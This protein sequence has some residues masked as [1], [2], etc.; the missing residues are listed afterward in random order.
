MQALY[1][2]I[3]EKAQTGMDAPCLAEKLTMLGPEVEECRAFGGT[4]DGLVVA[5]VITCERHPDSD[6]LSVCRV[7]MSAGAEAVIICGADNVRAGIKVLV[8]TAGTVLPDGTKIKKA[9]IR[10]VESNGM[11]CSREELG[12]EAKSKGIWILPDDAALGPAGTDILGERDWAYTMAITANRGDC[13]SINGL[14][15]EA[16]AAAGKTFTPSSPVITEDKTVEAPNITIE[17]GDLCAR[18][19]GRILRGVK[20]GPSPGWM[21]K[22]LEGCGMRSINNV[23]DITNYVLLEFG[24]PL[25]AFDLA[26]LEGRRIIVRRAGEGERMSTLDGQER[27]LSG[28]MLVIADARK[29]VALA[30]IMG[31]LE[32]EVSE[33]TVDVLLESAWFEPLSI[34][35]SS[36]RVGLASE[37][38]QRFG[39]GADP[40]GVPA[41]LDRAAA[42]IAEFAGARIGPMTDAEAREIPQTVINFPYSFVE[43]HLGT[44]P[45]LPEA[46]AI[47][48][49][50]GIET[51]ES[52]PGV[53][54]CRVPTWRS[55]LTLPA[56]IAEEI[57]RHFGY[58]R[59]E[60]R[61]F[62]VRINNAL[63]AAC[64][65]TRRILQDALASMGLTEAINLSFALQNN[66]EAAHIAPENCV[67]VANPLSSDQKYLRPSLLPNLLANLRYNFDHA[68]HNLALFEIGKVFLPAEPH[69]SERLHLAVLLCGK[70]EAEVW[71]DPDGR[72]YDFYDAKGMAGRIARA[73]GLES[74][75][76]AAAARDGWHPGRCAEIFHKK[77]K[78]GILGELHPEDAKAL[79]IAGR[80]IMIEM[81]IEDFRV[82]EGAAKQI[83][84][85]PKFPHLLRDLAFVVPEETECGALMESI[86]KSARFLE[87]IRLMSIFRGSQIGDGRKSLAFSLEFVCPDST[88]SDEEAGRIIEG[89]IRDLEKRHGARLR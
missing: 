44:A 9:K 82:G 35:R 8:A 38:S 84:E 26:R 53:L 21:V 14:A 88:L 80:V 72:D 11:I 31:G 87:S 55:D 59:M 68:Q 17:A 1:S 20:I 24:H 81:D 16:A 13:L 56:D 74:F 61:L 86:R 27:V 67:T 41:A 50:L 47:L 51:G 45:A 83:R 42:L 19:A 62:P 7:R 37:A 2:W 65:S 28:E 18:Y 22:R 78:I 66:L 15:R 77:K 71:I 76:F 39:R 70:A 36:R 54:A 49:R 46:K 29:P 69:P 10:G 89:I 23:V 60:A 85:I 75:S 43:K 4:L 58:D 57:A 48:S 40:G 6:H 30:G 79:D 52:A 5:E 34:R 64:D 3:E 12:L 33:D 63:L 32:S 73:L 25:H